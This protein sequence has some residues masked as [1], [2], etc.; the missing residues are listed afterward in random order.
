MADQFADLT[1]R[2]NV[3]TLTASGQ[4]GRQFAEVHFAR[5]ERAV[6]AHVGRQSIRLEVLPALEGRARELLKGRGGN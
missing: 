1:V 5:F 4:A 2:G 3:A 6:R